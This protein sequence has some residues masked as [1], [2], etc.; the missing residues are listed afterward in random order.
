MRMSTILWAVLMVSALGSGGPTSGT[1]PEPSVVSQSRGVARES[2]S[3]PTELVLIKPGTL[4]DRSVPPGWTHLVVKSIP[5]LA[6]GD[7]DTLPG[8]ASSTAT[9]FRTAILAEVKP[10]GDGPG[11]R[12]VLRRVGLGLCTPVQGRD[13]AVSSGSVSTQGIDLG[14]VGRTVLE[15]AEQELHRGRLIART[16]TFALFS[17]PCVIQSGKA[18]RQVLLR[19]AMLADPTTGALRTLVWAI[20]A[21]PASR[22]NA[23]T[24]VLIKPGVVYDCALDVAAE[25]IFGTVP[26]SWSFAIRSLPPGQPRVVS[27]DLQ[28]WSVRDL[29]TPLEVSQFEEA[30]RVSLA[31]SPRTTSR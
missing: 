25:R 8:M 20:A 13:T 3:P 21:D 27:A 30:L 29:R 16:S 2:A 9:L 7:L 31:D 12:Y 10:I 23:E 22:V 4:V 17:A 18:H 14:M 1:E 26:V 15:K 28:P 24:M 19:Y 11:R 6:S 5:R